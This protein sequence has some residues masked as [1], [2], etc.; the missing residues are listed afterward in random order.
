MRP[1]RVQS[2]AQ[3][4]QQPVIGHLPPKKHASQC[5]TIHGLA[6]LDAGRALSTRKYENWDSRL[7]LRFRKRII[8]KLFLACPTCNWLS[9]ICQSPMLLGPPRDANLPPPQIRRIVLS[10]RIFLAAP[11]SS[12]AFAARISAWSYP[13]QPDS[14]LT[15]RRTISESFAVA[16]S[17][18]RSTVLRSGNGNPESDFDCRD[19]CGS[20]DN[21]LLVVCDCQKE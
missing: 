16:V 15:L 8:K 1:E 10:Q 17:F 5:A 21:S 13:F 18:K 12:S 14:P 19:A 2:C 4:A 20:V 9:R 6:H 3:A 7:H 11:E